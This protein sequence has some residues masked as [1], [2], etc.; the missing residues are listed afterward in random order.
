[1]KSQKNDNCDAGSSP[2]TGPTPTAVT[3]LV[4]SAESESL[5]V[6]MFR[7]NVFYPL[8]DAVTMGLATRFDAVKRIDDLFGFLYK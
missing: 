1:M 3:G 8:I 4:T 7:V 5:N 6:A 2:W